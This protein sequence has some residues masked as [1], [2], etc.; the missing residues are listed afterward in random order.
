MPIPRPS[1]LAKVIKYLKEF[2][3]VGITQQTPQLG[4]KF[5]IAK[6]TF[7]P[8]SVKYGVRTPYWID[9]NTGNTITKLEPGQM[10]ADISADN[11]AKVSKV[12]NP[13]RVSEYDDF[14]TWEPEDIYSATP[15][16]A[17][18]IVEQ[19]QKKFNKPIVVPRDPQY[20]KY[21]G[22]VYAI[23]PTGLA[24]SADDDFLNQVKEASD[25]D[26]FLVQVYLESIQADNPTNNLPATVQSETKLA[27]EAHDQSMLDK[28]DKVKEEFFN[29][30][31]LKYYPGLE[32]I[33]KVADIFDPV[34]SFNKLKKWEYF[35][36]LKTKQPADSKDIK[37]YAK[38]R[39]DYW[40]SGLN[41]VG[42]IGNLFLVGQLIKFTG[43]AT[44][45][46]KIF[47]HT[48]SPNK[49]IIP[50]ETQ[51]VMQQADAINI[52]KADEIRNTV[53]EPTAYPREGTVLKPIVTREQQLL[54]LDV[55][56]LN[57][58]E[59]TQYGKTQV[60]PTTE[61]KDI[62]KQITKKNRLDTPENPNPTVFEKVKQIEAKYPDPFKQTPH[63]TVQAAEELDTRLSALQNYD[64]LGEVG[65]KTPF[66]KGKSRNL[67]DTE[68]SFSAF[69][70]TALARINNP[71]SEEI[72]QRMYQFSDDAERMTT[73][74][75]APLTEN[76][77]SK[78]SHKEWKN[79][80]DVL[81]DRYNMTHPNEKFRTLV[82]GIKPINDKVT[83]AINETFS[84]TKE[85]FEIAK[86]EGIPVAEEAREFFPMQPVSE[87]HDEKWLDKL[88]KYLVDTKQETNI[89]TAKSL[90]QQ[91]YALKYVDRQYAGI[92]KPR[93]FTVRGYDDL[94]ANGYNV[95]RNAWENYFDKVSHRLSEVKQWG[96]NGEKFEF[97][98]QR[99][100]TTHPNEA[101]IAE[102]AWRRLTHRDQIN[103]YAKKWADRAVN[104]TYMTFGAKIALMQI[105][106]IPSTFARFGYF[107]SLLQIPKTLKSSAF[108]AQKLGMT[109]RE[110][111][112]DTGTIYTN[113]VNEARTVMSRTNRLSD[114][115]TRF[116][117]ISKMDEI[118]R[119]HAT[120]S[121]KSYLDRGLKQLRAGKAE[122]YWERALREVFVDIKKLKAN[123]YKLDNDQYMSIIKRMTDSTIG[124]TRT[125]ELPIWASSPYANTVILFKKFAAFH[126]KFMKDQI[127]KHPE[128]WL[129]MMVAQYPIGA[130]IAEIRSKWTQRERPK[131]LMYHIDNLSMVQ[132][133]GL[134]G[135]FILQADKGRDMLM[136]TV[137]GP[138][139]G[140]LVDWGAINTQTIRKLMAGDP[141]PFKQFNNKFIDQWIAP[142]PFIGPYLQTELKDVLYPE[143]KIKRRQT[144]RR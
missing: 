92:E 31:E 141:K 102:R 137:A 87:I 110:F 44:K 36:E 13:L 136:R 56:D 135:D 116:T 120:W 94:K 21:A 69:V 80:V 70:N 71:Y 119:I 38:E 126:T 122:K 104:F 128:R 19:L 143:M 35:D 78:L 107:R 46:S 58:V 6:A 34:T 89:N 129:P 75:A 4:T 72:L 131:G 142:V 61:I 22:Q 84:K 8:E 100:A 30:P 50:N 133:M 117:G 11:F 77:L 16:Q 108:A 62:K 60:I 127:L 73:R 64:D 97:L 10:H 3:E 67:T 32:A 48:S 12:K 66:M 130:G 88:A 47:K 51:A 42:D 138:V 28:W 65:A 27:D 82:T 14:V 23:A 45:I 53:L 7:D 111:I 37:A 43:E 118:T 125:F 85:I 55:K 52:A 18:N 2:G 76:I 9:S 106:S 54:E 68:K 90:L 124:R 139:V 112:H 109:E 105:A 74:Y 103:V 115:Y 5:E 26:E 114:K 99:L 15:K 49:V 144:L 33:A 41:A 101:Q 25:Q 40:L 98:R 39:L 140:N 83:K 1:E 96:R 57:V 59:L 91:R 86:K 113:F 63:P 95:D 29:D 121:A 79:Y 24:V 123:G 93:E 20:G 81:T 134:L 17:E 132:A